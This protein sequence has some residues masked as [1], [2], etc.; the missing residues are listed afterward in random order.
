[1]HVPYHPWQD[2]N[3]FRAAHYIPANG[4][5]HCSGECE[6]SVDEIATRCVISYAR[7]AYPPRR[8]LERLGWRQRMKGQQRQHLGQLNLPL[9]DKSLDEQRNLEMARVTADSSIAAILNRLG[10]RTAK[11]HT[12]TQQ[13][14]RTFRSDHGIAI[15]RDGEPAERGE[16]TL[17]ES[18]DRLCVSKMTVVRLIKDQLLPAKQAC[19]GAPYVIREVDLDLPIVRRAIKNGR[20]TSP[21]PGQGLLEY[22]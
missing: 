13:R 19:I 15:Y 20:A 6:A 7:I 2:K 12:W 18:A 17:E 9:P 11:G 1:M 14:I 3:P 10:V 21:D 16:V 5:L 22:Q 4:Q 8:R